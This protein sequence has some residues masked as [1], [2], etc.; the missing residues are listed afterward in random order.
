MIKPDN[1]YLGDCLDLMGEMEDSSVDMIF[2]DPPFNIQKKYGKDATKDN[3]TDYYEW[4]EAWITEGFRVLKDTGTFYLMTLDRHLE[5]KLPMMG[6]HGV[7]INIVKWRNV[8]AAHDRRRFWESTQPIIVYGKT[9][10][11]SFNQYGER[12]KIP[13]EGQRWG[14]YT[15]HAKGQ[16][17]DF[18]DDIPLVYAGGAHHKEAILK[19]G[20]NSKIHPAQMPIGLPERAIRFSTNK[21]D[22]ILDP[23]IGSGTTAIAAIRTGRHYIG[24]EK[25]PGYYNMV[26]ERI[27][28]ATEQ[29]KLT[30]WFEQPIEAQ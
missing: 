30:T 7:F 21:G 1:I 23:F 22:L 20:T 27:N 5:K 2:A 19:P 16:L 8:S 9:S 24:F 14:R 15:T 26:Q 3:R 28:K 6:K 4:C 12:R 17:L 13:K 18:W 29:D 11:Y 10:D 25:D